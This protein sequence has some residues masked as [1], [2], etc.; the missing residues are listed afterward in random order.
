MRKSKKKSYVYGETKSHTVIQL[1]QCKDCTRYEN[2][3]CLYHSSEGNELICDPDDF[4]SAGKRK[5][6]V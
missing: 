1:V 2:G 4:C 6:Q 5:E 3:L